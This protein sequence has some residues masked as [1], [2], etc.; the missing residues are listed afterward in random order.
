MVIVSKC[1]LLLPRLIVG[2]SAGNPI[3]VDKD[4]TNNVV[5]MDDD[6]KLWA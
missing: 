3:H 5:Y 4:N 2:S 6:D 1:R